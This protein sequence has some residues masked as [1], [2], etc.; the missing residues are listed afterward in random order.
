MYSFTYLPKRG[1]T[2]RNILALS[3]INGTSVSPEIQ[4]L[5]DADLLDQ[6]CLPIALTKPQIGVVQQ[7]LDWNGRGAVIT[8]TALEA[9]S[10]GLVSAAMRQPSTTLIIGTKLSLPHWEKLIEKVY[11]DDRMVRYTNKAEALG[12]KWILTT[13][14]GFL[15]SK[16]LSEITFDQ[17]IID[18]MG[19]MIG[20]HN[21]AEAVAGLVREIRSTLCLMSLEDQPK[22]LPTADLHSPKSGLTT[23]LINLA[24][25]LW[26][27]TDMNDLFWNLDGSGGA[28]LRAR[29]YL[30]VAPVDLFPTM[31]IFT[32]LVR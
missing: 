18:D 29:G 1:A 6:A 27:T 19:P 9:R 24:N 12:A 31:G 23:N 5:K 21:R 28:Y 32:A 14:T 17:C 3:K 2:A 25:C 7:V 8:N 22:V 26:H 11:P 20:H 16:I 13:L 15:K 10:V 30:S 4:A